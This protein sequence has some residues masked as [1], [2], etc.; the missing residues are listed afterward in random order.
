MFSF[1]SLNLKIKIFPDRILWVTKKYHRLDDTGKIILVPF[2]IDTAVPKKV[3]ELT[4]IFVSNG[5]AACFPK[6]SEN[7]LHRY[8]NMLWYF[9]SWKS[10]VIRIQLV[11]SK[12]DN[13]CTAILR[14]LRATFVFVT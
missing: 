7:N 1:S 9:F 3:Y 4:E 14:K 8:G 11:I 5:A 2:R 12:R 10:H 13:S 6:V